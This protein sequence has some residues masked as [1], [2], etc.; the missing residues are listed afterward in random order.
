MAQKNQVDLDDEAELAKLIKDED[1]NVV[2][3]NTDV[4]EIDKLTGVPKNNDQLLFAV[5]MLAPYTTINTFKFKAKV[6]PG[7]LKRGRA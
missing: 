2:P 4:S 3:E 1:I 7:T 6:T 5:P